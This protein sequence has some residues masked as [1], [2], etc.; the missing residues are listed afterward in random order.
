MAGALLV[1][2]R[3][4]AVAYLIQIAFETQRGSRDTGDPEVS[5]CRTIFTLSTDLHS[6]DY[7]HFRC[8]FAS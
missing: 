8:E 4:L 1:A 6:S 2:S 5:G 7:Q 3:Y